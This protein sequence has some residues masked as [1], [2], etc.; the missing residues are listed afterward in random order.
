MH[1]NEL[2]QI[3]EYLIILF[4]FCIIKIKIC[5]CI[6]SVDLIRKIDKTSTLLKELRGLKQVIKYLEM[7]RLP[8]LL[9]A[10]L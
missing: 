9:I 7:I 6:K 1:S 8:M 5:S 2:I 4:R 10:K 3:M